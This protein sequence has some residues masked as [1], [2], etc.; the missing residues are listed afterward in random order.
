MSLHLLILK[1]STLRH[2]WYSYNVLLNT[3]DTSTLYSLSKRW[4]DI[5]VILPEC[6]EFAKVNIHKNELSP[7][8]FF[9]KMGQPRPL[10]FIFVL[11][12]NNFM[13]KF[14]DLSGIRTRIVGVEGE[15]ADHL[16]TTTAQTFTNTLKASS[17]L[18]GRVRKKQF[19]RWIELDYRDVFPIIK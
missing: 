19:L 11:F 18:R 17:I 12:N 7:I 9:K 10:L 16:T 8:L 6:I 1:S 5:V 14:I 2:S 4:K 13:R 15:H 3:W